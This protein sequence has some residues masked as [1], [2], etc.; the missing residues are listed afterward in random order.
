MTASRRCSWLAGQRRDPRLRARDDMADAVGSIV[1]ADVRSRPQRS[2]AEWSALFETY[3]SASPVDAWAFRQ[4]LRALA[5]S[6]G[7]APPRGAAGRAGAGRV[8]HPRSIAVIA[9]AG[10]CRGLAVAPQLAAFAA[11]LGISTRFVVA[12][13]HDAAASLWAACSAERGPATPGAAARGEDRGTPVAIRGR[14]SCRR[15]SR[16]STSSSPGGAGRRGG[17]AARARDG[18]DD[19]PD[20]PTGHTTGSPDGRRRGGRRRPRW[21]PVPRR[22]ERDRGASGPARAHPASR[23]RRRPCSTLRVVPKHHR[24]TSPS[25]SPW[26]T[27]RKPDA[28]RGPAH[29]GDGARARAGRGQPGAARPPRG[30]GRRRRAADRRRRRRGPGPVGPHDGAADAGRAR[31]QA[32]LP[33][34]I[35]GIGQ[36][37]MSGSERGRPDERARRTGA[38]RERGGLGLGAHGGRRRPAPWNAPSAWNIPDVA[39]EETGT[40]CA[41]SRRSSA[42]TTCVPRSGAG[43]CGSS[44]PRCWDCSCGGRRSWRS[45]P[46]CPRRRRRCMLTHDPKASIRMTRARRTS[47]S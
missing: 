15:A 39:P 35:T 10:D 34:R 43:G 14:R 47:A 31:R 36:A 20:A 18:R 9:V 37:P 24:P 19:L 7:S 27:A 13:G 30:R 12:S 11:S 33:V 5:Y 21:P 1:L 6:A 46:P 16:R 23:P 25:C 4:L 29:R 26:S 41:R 22:T 38:A 42:S 28:G 32:P 2:V 8:D 17:R 44:C 40:R 45:I 3:V